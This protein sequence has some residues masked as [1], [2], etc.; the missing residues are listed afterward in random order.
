MHRDCRSTEVDPSPRKSRWPNGT[1]HPRRALPGHRDPARPLHLVVLLAAAALLGGCAA[2]APVVYV[3]P[4]ASPAQMAR[5]ERDTADCRRLAMASVGL[6]GRSAAALAR[7]SG[8]GGAVGF[9]GTA[10]GAV[11]ANSKDALNRA[12]AGAAAGATGVATKVLLEW[13]EPDKVHQ[14]YVDRC[15]EDRGHDVLGWR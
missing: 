8:K 11:V 6:N 1:G 12:K 2:T 3:K 5:V 7:D 14:G 13:N 15:M 10:V 4:G 9:V